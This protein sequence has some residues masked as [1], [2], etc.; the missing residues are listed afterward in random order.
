MENIND[1]T[2]EQ[3]QDL[4]NIQYKTM[5]MNGVKTDL[6]A[7]IN[8]D[9]ERIEKMLDKEKGNRK[10]ISWSRMSKISRIK[11]LNQYANSYKDKNNLSEKEYEALKKY[12]SNALDRKRLIKVKEVKYDKDEEC[13]LDIPNLVFNVSSKKFTLKRSDKKKSTLSSLGLG[14]TKKR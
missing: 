1:N 11:K 14:K 4:K 7:S 2:K 12:L 5:L 13:I 6:K 3:C 10:N 8:K 9:T